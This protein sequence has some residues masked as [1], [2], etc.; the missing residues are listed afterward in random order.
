MPET[1]DGAEHR[2][3]ARQHIFVV[4]GAPN[5]LSLVSELLQSADFNVTTTN[6]VPETFDMVAALDPALLIVDLEIGQ[7]A[8]WDLLEHLQRGAATRGL[9]V[10]LSSTE[11][12][13]L[14]QARADADRYGSHRLFIKPFD[15]ADLVAT[16]HDIIGRAGAVE[17]PH[18]ITE[19]SRL[20]GTPQTLFA[21]PVRLPAPVR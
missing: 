1:G 19:H 17:A 11:P 13:L 6:Y 15:I 3:M 10:L 8:G 16:V 4:T 5:F 7:Q 12:Y 9:P 21:H 14:A 2:R 20:H 18:P